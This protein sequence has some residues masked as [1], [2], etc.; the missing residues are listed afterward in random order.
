MDKPVLRKRFCDICNE[1]VVHELTY[2]IDGAL[3][4]C[5]MC[6]KETELDWNKGDGK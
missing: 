4:L 3:C 1:I 2:E 5:L 6:G